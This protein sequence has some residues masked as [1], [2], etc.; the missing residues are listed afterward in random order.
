M[1][2]E[3]KNGNKSTGRWKSGKFPQIRV[4]TKV[5]R[6]KR[7]GKKLWGPVWIVDDLERD[8]RESRKG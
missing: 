1:K 3:M 2:S 6:E 8:E 7:K 5:E 4:E